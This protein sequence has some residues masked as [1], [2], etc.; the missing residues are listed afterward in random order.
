MSR[1]SRT[2]SRRTRSRSRSASSLGLDLEP[3]Y[4]YT[5]TYIPN[6]RSNDSLYASPY[7]VAP[8]SNLDMQREIRR[9]KWSNEGVH[10]SRAVIDAMNA[11]TGFTIPAEDRY[12]KRMNTFAQQVIPVRY[13]TCPLGWNKHTK[14]TDEAR[15]AGV[16]WQTD[17]NYFCSPPDTKD[18]SSLVPE[19]PEYESPAEL[20]R[21]IQELSREMKYL[22]NPSEENTE[23]YEKE[24][25]L[26][27]AQVAAR[28]LAKAARE[29]A[30]NK[31]KESVKTREVA[32]IK[33][34]L[35]KRNPKGSFRHA[36]KIETEAQ[37]LYET[38]RLCIS[39]VPTDIVERKARESLPSNDAGNLNHA[40]VEEEGLEPT[41][42]TQLR[43]KFYVPYRIWA[44]DKDMGDPVEKGLAQWWAGYNRRARAEADNKK[45]ERLVRLG[46]I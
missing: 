17:D 40:I 31:Q 18:K 46:L 2:R 29:T 41:T 11:A 28:K 43:K 10:N 27:K 36:D 32:A 26:I 3:S 42:V 16:A 38:A 39:D 21:R 14:L 6:T 30:L 7:K 9:T 24:V 37:Q 19:H 5:P 20:N 8:R 23:E 13:P 22:L 44:S 4:Q 1:R 45:R 15:A 34:I 33:A 12:L 35:R 25:K